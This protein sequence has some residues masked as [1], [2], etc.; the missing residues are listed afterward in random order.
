[1]TKQ[2]AP[3]QTKAPAT[4]S[5]AR[6]TQR[7]RGGLAAGGRKRIEVTV[8]PELEAAVRGVASGR[9][10][11]IEPARPDS[12]VEAKARA[13]RELED[14]L[15]SARVSSLVIRQEVAKLARNWRPS[16]RRG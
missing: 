7:Y 6:R 5:G 2:K 10:V 14:R 4:T 13:I 3:G 11:A 16:T 8:P 12:P 15:R 1:M 9:M